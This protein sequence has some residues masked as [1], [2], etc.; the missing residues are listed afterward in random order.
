MCTRF[1]LFVWLLALLPLA[2]AQAQVD[3]DD[4]PQ[5]AA[6]KRIALG[7][8]QDLWGSDNTDR[9]RDYLADEYVVH[10]I[11]GR[12]GVTEPAVEQMRIADRFW[13]SGTMDFELDYQIAEGDLVATR[14]IWRYEPET[15]LMKFLFGSTSIP[16]INV[17][18]IEDGKIVELW[19]HRHDIDTGITRVFV[20]MGFGL[21]LLVA[22]IPTVIAIRLRRKLRR[23]Q[24]S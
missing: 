24:S 5:E 1:L 14:W 22:L 7:F 23:L 2:L 12:N 19:N 3:A 13:D 15:L 16:I 8:Y 18:R 10:D 20:L 11:G 6:N 9:Y 21:G 17:F 4:T